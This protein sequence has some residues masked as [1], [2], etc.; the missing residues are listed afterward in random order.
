MINIQELLNEIDGQ[1]DAG[2]TVEISH[3]FSNSPA[4]SSLFVTYAV[5]VAIGRDPMEGLSILMAMAFQLGQLHQQKE[6]QEEIDILTK[7]LIKQE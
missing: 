4:F 3:L 2:T 7:Q 5:G 6:M 1:I